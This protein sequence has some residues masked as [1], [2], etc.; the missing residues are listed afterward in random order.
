M[1]GNESA[2]ASEEEFSEVSDTETSSET[3]SVE[4]VYEEW[5]GFNPSL[6]T[7]IFSETDGKANMEPLL[8]DPHPKPGLFPEIANL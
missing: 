5:S 8:R 6:N 2:D 3:D 4:T 1:A 7:P